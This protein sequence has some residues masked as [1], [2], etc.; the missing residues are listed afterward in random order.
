MLDPSRV[1]S[2]VGA[3]LLVVGACA[4]SA[5]V[6]EAF[7]E[8][9]ESLKLIPSCKSDPD[10]YLSIKGKYC[11]EGTCCDT[12]C[13]GSCES[14]RAGTK[15]SGTGDGIC[16][17]RKAGT[18]PR[19]AGD[20]ATDESNE[21]G[22]DGTCDGKGE[23]LQ[24]VPKGRKCGNATPLCNLSQNTYTQNICDGQGA[25]VIDTQSC[26]PGVCSAKGCTTSCA[27]PDECATKICNNKVCE[28]PQKLGVA[29]ADGVQCAS[30]FC[31]DGVCC[32]SAC[33]DT[34]GS[35]L[36]AR[37]GLEDGS[38]GPVKAGEDPD[39]DCDPAPPCG[40]DGQCDGNYAC[41]TV[42]AKVTCGDTQCVSGQLSGSSCDGLGACDVVKERSCAPYK[43]C[44]S[45]SEC[46]DSCQNSA[47]CVDGYFCD[48]GQC[49]ALKQNICDA[50]ETSVVGVEGVTSCNGFRCRAGECMTSCA[51]TAKDCAAPYVCDQ[52]GICT[53]PRGDS[54]DDDP[55][56]SVTATRNG[57]PSVPSWLGIGALLLLL[58]RRR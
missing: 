41:R 36:G 54:G 35:C 12:P 52:S 6:P 53:L 13:S 20:C 1:V 58:R 51:D 2:L 48:A 57:A 46:E 14:C 9:G 32:D 23:C 40:N 21:C 15:Q 34:C 24:V 43:T 50:D 38:C 25:C 31:V 55:G 4:F 7:G 18:K 56:C 33:D 29:C 49:Q 16:G 10:C 39:D 26:T 17:P 37:T 27:N 8:K 45:G 30:G 44:K 22:A 28:L 11:V 5:D 47:D 42:S 3:T 19:V